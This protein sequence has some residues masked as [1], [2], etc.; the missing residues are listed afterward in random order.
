MKYVS[1]IIPCYNAEKFL[2]KNI[3]TLTKI[4]NKRKL[5]YE[6]IL[7]DDGS[8]DN[9]N[10]IIKKLKYKF[11]RKICLS[12]NFGKSFAVRSALKLAKFKHVILI[13]CD[14]PYIDKLNLVINKLKDGYD[15][16]AI[17]RRHKK[18]NLKKTKLNTYQAFR[19][20]TGKMISKIIYISLPVRLKTYDTQAGLKG[21]RTFKNFK[22]FK[23]IS[24]K[25]F[26]DLELFYVFHK[27]KKLFYFIPT[28]YKINKKS[29]I[30]F[31]SINNFKIIYELITV[32]I[33][34][35]LNKYKFSTNKK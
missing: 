28:N 17:D 21:I 4:I 19:Y 11:L 7:I 20:F 10:K 12:K 2:E 18:S 22:D 34:I 8:T 5:N 29:S 13:D 23:F 25:F 15:F 6:L 35:W 32:I 1:V 26:L 31:I 30:K 3:R 9:T 27:Y 14:L 16:I 33:K 24:K